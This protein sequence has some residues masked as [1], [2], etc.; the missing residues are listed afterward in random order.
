MLDHI[1]NR[2]SKFIQVR[3]GDVGGQAA[4]FFGACFS[5]DGYTILAYSYFGGFYSWQVEK[6]SLQRF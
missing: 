2:L 3:V 6:V 5:P 4:G 1:Y